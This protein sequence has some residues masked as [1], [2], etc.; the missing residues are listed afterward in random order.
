MLR[1]REEM[2]AQIRPFLISMPNEPLKY[3]K[4]RDNIKIREMIFPKSLVS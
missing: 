1:L 4:E 2:S 3:H